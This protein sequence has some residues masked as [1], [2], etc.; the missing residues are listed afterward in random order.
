M[1]QSARGKKAVGQSDQ[2]GPLLYAGKGGVDGKRAKR[3]CSDDK[4]RY[5]H[6]HGFADFP[7]AA[8]SA[9]S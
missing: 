7:K 2:T 1:R 5:G 6:I 4:Q 9:T 8:G 3:A